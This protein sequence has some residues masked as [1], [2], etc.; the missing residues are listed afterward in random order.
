MS[1]NWTTIA[2]SGITASIICSFQFF[3]TRYLGRMLD[4]IEKRLGVNGKKVEDIKK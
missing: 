4:H 3:T 2:A 1:L